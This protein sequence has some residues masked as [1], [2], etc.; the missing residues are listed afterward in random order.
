MNDRNS[1]V[2]SQYPGLCSLTILASKR[3]SSSTS[4]PSSSSPSS[5]TSSSSSSQALSGVVGARQGKHEN[6]FYSPVKIFLGESG[7]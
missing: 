6:G 4:S 5:S 2:G 3:G 7:Y 1:M